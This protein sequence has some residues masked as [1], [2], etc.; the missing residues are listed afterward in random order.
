M[1]FDLGR[2]VSVEDKTSDVPRIINM[3]SLRQRSLCVD[4]KFFLEDLD[5]P[6]NERSDVFTNSSAFD[7]VIE[8]DEESCSLCYCMW[9]L[10]PVD[11][12]QSTSITITAKYRMVKIPRDCIIVTMLAGDRRMLGHVRIDQRTS[13][14]A[15][16]HRRVPTM[17]FG[18]ISRLVR[19]CEAQHH[20]F[21]WSLPRY[22]LST[23]IALIDVEDMMII[24]ATTERRYL[25]LS[26]VWGEHLSFETTMSNMASLRHK[27]GLGTYMGEIPRT[28]KDAMDVVRNL[29]ERY[30]WVDRLCIEQDN[31]TQKKVHIQKMD[32]IYSHALMTIIAHAGV[33]ATSPLPG[34]RPGT[35]LNMPT[36]QIGDTVMS[37]RAPTPWESG[38]PHETRGW[39]LQ[40]Q[41]MSKRCL[42]FDF[43]TTWFQCD[44]GICREIDALGGHDHELL[45]PPISFNMQ[46]LQSRLVDARD[47]TRRL[48]YAWEIYAT[49][50]ERY[51]TRQ[52]RYAEDAV[53]GMEG[54]ARL[55]SESLGEPLISGVPLSMMPR[56]MQFYF[57][58]EG[59][60]LGRN[61]TAPSWSWAGWKDS[62]F[63]DDPTVAEPVPAE[64][65]ES[66]MWV[67]YRTSR[68]SEAQLQGNLQPVASEVKDSADES[69]LPEPL[70]TM[71]DIECWYTTAS[72]FAFKS[73][74]EASV[75]RTLGHREILGS[76]LYVHDQAGSRCGHSLGKHPDLLEDEYRSDRLQWILVS[77]SQPIVVGLGRTFPRP[78]TA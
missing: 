39:T 66:A 71:L 18:V 59:S 60:V 8:E 12:P 50:V 3:Q 31:V 38:A 48:N 51:R 34:L 37:V 32:V 75:G 47:R 58:G 62:I 55:I 70:Y 11:L 30:L 20:H 25:A 64:A 5:T 23:S 76:V 21:N 4:C 44:K 42:Y 13:A 14:P 26:Y 2:P 69:S 63:F 28:I 17:D 7:Y 43:H 6:L 61:G 24:S 46:P 56:A 68:L 65:V 57:S 78:F 15:Q 53:P 74:R 45:Q 72:A 40:E 9:H 77:K 52:L 36:K 67:R 22:K 10:I 35:R 33:A 49:I 54:V 16:N 19:E 1:E 73:Y 41:L 29:G 27:G